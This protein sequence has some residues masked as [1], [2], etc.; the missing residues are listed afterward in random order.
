[1]IIWFFFFQPIEWQ[2]FISRTRIYWECPIN[3]PKGKKKRKLGKN[4]WFL[5]YQWK[6]YFLMITKWYNLGSNMQIRIWNEA[7]CSICFHENGFVILDC[8]MWKIKNQIKKSNRGKNCCFFIY[9]QE[10]IMISIIALSSGM[11]LD[12][13]S[14]SRKMT[15]LY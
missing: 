14:V 10:H 4:W 9:R 12:V 8:L 3:L 6:K 5:I 15:L 13:V 11:K 2:S 1:M 7:V